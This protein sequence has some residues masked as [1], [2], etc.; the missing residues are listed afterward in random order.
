MWASEAAHEHWRMTTID[1]VN[2]MPKN[3]L[4]KSHPSSFTGI[5]MFSGEQA[6][7]RSLHAIIII[8]GFDYQRVI[9]TLS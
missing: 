5:A 6:Y 2:Q 1:R 4:K 7:I 8:Q 9:I 3:K